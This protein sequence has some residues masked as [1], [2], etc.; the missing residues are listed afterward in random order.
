MIL[1]GQQSDDKQAIKLMHGI[2]C[3]PER[4]RLSSK[5]GDSPE[6]QVSTEIKV[7]S[8]EVAESY[9]KNIT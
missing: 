7:W 2:S 8:W 6:K 5:P 3:P 9:K 4:L 1:I